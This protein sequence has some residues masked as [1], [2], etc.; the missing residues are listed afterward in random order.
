V[1]RNEMVT[2]AGWGC[3]L[4]CFFYFLL[5]VCGFWFVSAVVISSVSA[6]FVLVGLHLAHIKERFFPLDLFFAEL[7]GVGIA[8]AACMM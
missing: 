7:V 6:F 2:H 8:I 3:L 1:P 4:T 5:R